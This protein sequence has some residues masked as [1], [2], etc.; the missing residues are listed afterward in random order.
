MAWV[1][2]SRSNSKILHFNVPEIKVIQVLQYGND[3][4]AERGQKN[5]PEF[6]VCKLN[7]SIII[8]KAG[9]QYLKIC[10]EYSTYTNSRSYL[11][12]LQK[13]WSLRCTLLDKAFASGSCKCFSGNW[14]LNN[15]EDQ[16]A[17][18]CGLKWMSSVFQILLENSP[19]RLSKL[20]G[21]SQT[22][23][24]KNMS[25]LNIFLSANHCR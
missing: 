25:D 20:C 17:W 16:K 1:G 14:Q 5:S 15:L 21:G 2:I 22:L 6:S 3:F 18:Q 9:F 12:N 19:Q 24:L 7:S 13:L 10:T 23:F 11:W 4:P 8:Y